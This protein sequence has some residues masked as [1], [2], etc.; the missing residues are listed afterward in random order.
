MKDVYEFLKKIGFYFLASV[1][2]N[3]PKV[4]PFGTVIIFEDK[5]YIQSSKTKQ[6][7]KQIAINPK[8][9]ISASTADTWLRIE[10]EAVEDDRIEPKEQVLNEYPFLRSNY[11]DNPDSIVWYLKNATATIEKFGIE[12][13]IFHF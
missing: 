7:A 3:Q 6:V 10:A 5:I 4:R 9:A 8:I 11:Q 12:K 13:Q 1:D 2:G